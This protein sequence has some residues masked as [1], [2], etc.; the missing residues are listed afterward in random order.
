MDP[1][2]SRFEVFADHVPGSILQRCRDSGK[3]HL[4]FFASCFRS[5]SPSVLRPT[6]QEADGR[7]CSL[8][9][10]QRSSL[11]FADTH[12]CSLPAACCLRISTA[13]MFK[14]NSLPWHCRVPS[15]RNISDAASR[16]QL[17]EYKGGF[18]MVQPLYTP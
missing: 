4:I 5:W 2:W 18:N 10:K 11:S 14:S 16:L 6:A 7:W 1:A 9:T 8:T 12:P 17:A 15:K 13:W 3:T